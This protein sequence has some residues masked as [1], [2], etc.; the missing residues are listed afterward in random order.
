[1][2]GL[3][4]LSERVIPM[5]FHGPDFLRSG[6]ALKIMSLGITFVFLNLMARYVLTAIDRQR[7]YLWAIVAGVLTNVAVGFALIRSHGFVG[8]C[9][10]QLGAEAA[11]LVV[12]Q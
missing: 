10:A 4:L 2:T 8:A 1:M 12:C 5:L 9:I 7:I 3:F 11:I 6:V